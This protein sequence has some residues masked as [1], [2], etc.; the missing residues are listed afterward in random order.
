MDSFCAC[1]SIAQRHKTT[2]TAKWRA[3][4]QNARTL[5][6]AVMFAGPHASAVA[7][8]SRV[9]KM[10]KLATGLGAVLE[11]RQLNR[12]YSSVDRSSALE[13]RPEQ[14]DIVRGLERHHRLD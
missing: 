10:I 13:Q 4:R 11:G 6:S 9:Y 1:A 8:L 7:Q 2:S 12:K 5:A 14:P 3:K